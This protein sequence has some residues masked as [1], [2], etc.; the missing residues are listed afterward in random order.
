MK[1]AIL[2]YFIIVMVTLFTGCKT[3]NINDYKIYENE[4]EAYDEEENLFKVK[5][6]QV[7]GLGNESLENVINQTLK[8]SITEWINESCEWMD[9][10]QIIIKYK[11]SKYLSLCY[12]IEWK[13]DRGEDYISEYTRIGVTVDMQTGERVY[14]DDLIEDIGGLKKDLE[15]Y[16]YG[17]EFSPPIN[18]DEADE[19]IHNSSISEKKYLNEIYQNNPDVY[20]F[21]KSYIGLKQSFYLTDNKLVITRDGYDLN[22]VY[23]DFEQ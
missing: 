3:N 22:D 10:F 2:I 15:K 23:I 7:S 21:I 11:T 18:S 1:R 12:T 4:Y 6:A 20:R 8:L 14:L 9:K 13:D 16:D 5:Y 17:N 19:I